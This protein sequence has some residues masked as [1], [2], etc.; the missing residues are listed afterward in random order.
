MR[1][2]LLALT[3]ALAATAVFAAR[4]QAARASCVAVIVWHDTAYFGYSTSGVR[5]HPPPGPRVRGAVQ[6]ACNDTGGGAGSPTSVDARAIR[7]V[8]PQVGL[9]SN[10]GIYV[11]AGEFPQLPG[12]PIRF[13]PVDD[14]T[15]TCRVTAHVTVSGHVLPA[16]GEVDLADVRSTRPLPLFDQRL[17]VLVDVHTRIAGLDRNGV[18]Y[19]G[20][21]QAVRIDALRCG[22]M[23]VAT[24]IV[25]AGPIAPAAT[26]EDVLG[27][28][29]RGGPGLVSDL[30]DRTLFVAVAL[31]V[32]GMAAVIAVRRRRRSPASG[33]G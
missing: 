1:R 19:I 31:T 8:P 5:P 32:A 25:P 18:P 22:H 14:A 10:G 21:L 16:A 3:L 26:A 30:Q 11:P 28:H 13:R 9:V 7:G 4:P 2:L 20:R 23:I 12:F 27:P 15:R 29:W 17:S 33:A 24:R 6:P